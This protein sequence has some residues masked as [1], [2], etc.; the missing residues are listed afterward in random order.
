MCDAR[1]TTLVGALL[2][3]ATALCSVPAFAQVD[4]SGEWAVRYHEDFEER[5]PGGEL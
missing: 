1:R 3:L 5:S 2:L 4:F